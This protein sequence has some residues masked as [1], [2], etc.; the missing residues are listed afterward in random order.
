MTQADRDNI[1]VAMLLLTAAIAV[2]HIT[3]RPPDV[4][5]GDDVLLQSLTWPGD[6]GLLPSQR[7]L[8]G[9]P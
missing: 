6:T 5:L 1:T 2:A 7:P 4:V 8:R 3:F 9:D